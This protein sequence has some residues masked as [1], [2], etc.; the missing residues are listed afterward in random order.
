MILRQAGPLRVFVVVTG[1]PGVGKSTLARA[2]AGKMGLVLLE[3]DRIEVPLFKQGLDGVA[4]GW[5][6]YEALTASAEDNLSAVTRPSA[7]EGRPAQHYRWAFMLRRKPLS[8]LLRCEGDAGGLI[9][10]V[11]L[12]HA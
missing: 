2:L 1:L 7:S 11:R 3:L 8:E 12:R 9:G 4:V 6:A 5:R 10:E